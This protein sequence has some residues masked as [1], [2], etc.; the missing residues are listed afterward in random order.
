MAGTDAAGR[1]PLGVRVEPRGQWVVVRLDGELDYASS[2]DLV[3]VLGGVIADGGL[4]VA[5]DM[6]GLEFFDSSGLARVL[7]AATQVRR[8]GGQLVVVDGQQPNLRR[9]LELMGAAKLLPVV[10]AVPD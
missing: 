4:C 10:P 2:V 7:Q 5:V 8:L 6:S 9:R 1:S 3:M